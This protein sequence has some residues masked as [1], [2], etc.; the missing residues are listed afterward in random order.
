MYNNWPHFIQQL[1]LF[2]SEYGHSQVPDL[3]PNNQTLATWARLMRTKKMLGSLTNDQLIELNALGFEWTSNHK[4]WQQNFFDLQEFY[5]I[6]GHFEVPSKQ[7]KLRSWLAMVKKQYNN[8]TLSKEHIDAL[9]MIG[10]TF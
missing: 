5:N 2:K 8:K 9:K 7:S 10:F 3:L 1:I 4:S 6:H